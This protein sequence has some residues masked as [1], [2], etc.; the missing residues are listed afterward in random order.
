YGRGVWKVDLIG[1]AAPV[2][3]F[4][5]TPPICT[6]VPKVFTDNSINGPTTWTWTIAPAVGVTINT[7]SSQNPTVTFANSGVY[8]VSLATSNGF[9]PGTLATQTINVITTP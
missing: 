5:V 1:N 7:P 6:G 3:S 8:S 9:G 2:S 4:T